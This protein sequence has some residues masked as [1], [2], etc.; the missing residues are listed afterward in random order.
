LIL[1]EFSKLVGMAAPGG[2]EDNMLGRHLNPFKR[3]HQKPVAYWSGIIEVKGEKELSYPVPEDFN[4]KLR[5]MAVAVNSEKIGIFQNSTTVR[6]D[7][8][9]SPNVPGMVAPGDEFEVSV[10]VANNLTGLGGKE[11]PVAVEIKSPAQIEVIG[12]A[13]QEISL[14]ELREGVVVL[15][16]NIVGLVWHQGAEASVWVAR[17]AA[18]GRWPGTGTLPIVGKPPVRSPVGIPEWAVIGIGTVTELIRVL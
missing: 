5:I 11:I 12:K 1:P 13:V 2:D 3:K 8:V 9:L 16:E 4:G 18:V 15:N 6:G 10:G 14:G 7:F 17:G